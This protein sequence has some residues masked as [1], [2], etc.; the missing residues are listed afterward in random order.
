MKLYWSGETK[1]GA[2]SDEYSGETH[3]T[4]ASAKAEL[5]RAVAWVARHHAGD[6]ISPPTFWLDE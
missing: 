5:E 4:L 2:F 1:E 6:F 3:S